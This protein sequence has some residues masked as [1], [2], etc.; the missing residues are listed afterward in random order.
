MFVCFPHPGLDAD[1]AILY[2]QLCI[3]VAMHTNKWEAIAVNLDIDR[4]EIERIGMEC[5]DDIQGCFRRVFDK[6]RRSGAPPFAW[7]TIIRV[8]KS[9]NVAENF[10]ASNLQDR[11]SPE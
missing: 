2:K 10:L 5:R 9:A 4:T 11:H 1:G 7:D 3:E 8:L 6:W